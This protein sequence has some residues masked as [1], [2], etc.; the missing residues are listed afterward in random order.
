LTK[1][2]LISAG[3]KAD[4]NFVVFRAWFIIN[5]AMPLGPYPLRANENV[6]SSQ[7]LNRFCFIVGAACYFADLIFLMISQ[8][9]G[10]GILIVDFYLRPLS[11]MQE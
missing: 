3:A 2:Y 7:N 9:E 6:R 10:A 8:G 5:T 11:R 4:I 1:D